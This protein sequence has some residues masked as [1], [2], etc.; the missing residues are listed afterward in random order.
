MINYSYHHIIIQENKGFYRDLN[1]TVAK[2][3]SCSG[4]YVNLW[5][6]LTP[7]IWDTYNYVIR[8]HYDF[9]NYLINISKNE[10][11]N[12]ENIQNCEWSIIDKIP[13]N[14]IQKKNIIYND[15]YL[16]WIIFILIIIWCIIF[17]YYKKKKK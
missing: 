13:E 3:I 6:S 9:D 17:K 10:N 16:W 12:W 8:K 11:P 7:Q 2:E 15:F 14:I 1:G 4:K 5:N